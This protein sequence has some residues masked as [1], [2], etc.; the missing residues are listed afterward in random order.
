MSRFA[1]V[2]SDLSKLHERFSD[3][4]TEIAQAAFAQQVGSDSNA[5]CPVDTQQTQD[6]ME[7][8]SDFKAGNIVWDT[9]WA[10]IAYSMP[11]SIIKKSKNPLARSHWF[12]AA[13]EERLK[14]WMSIIEKGYG[15]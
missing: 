8:A 15:A 10:A 1:I 7:T 12:E 9:D 4:A 13:K 2:D 3:S 6:S 11:D 5:H 14:D